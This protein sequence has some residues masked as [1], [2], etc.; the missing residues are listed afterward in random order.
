M[1][2][3]MFNCS[4]TFSFAWQTETAV[5]LH[6]TDSCYQAC[7]RELIVIRLCVVWGYCLSSLWLILCCIL[8]AIH[9]QQQYKIASQ[10]KAAIMQM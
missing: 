8:S 5:A 10:C 6:M 1:L 4:A 7:F 2:R 9:Y 3:G